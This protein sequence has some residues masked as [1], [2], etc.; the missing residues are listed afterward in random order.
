MK[1]L[2]NTILSGFFVGGVA[3][4]G[5]LIL[6]FS[7]AEWFCFYSWLV[8]ILFIVQILIGKAGRK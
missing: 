4:G 3:V 7:G 2:L 1:R 6:K 8:L 5:L